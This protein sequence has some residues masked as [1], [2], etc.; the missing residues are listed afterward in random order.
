MLLLRAALQRRAF[1]TSRNAYQAVVVDGPV[2]APTTPV[3]VKKPMGAFRG[4]YGMDSF[5]FV[6]KTFYTLSS[7]PI[8]HDGGL[9]LYVITFMI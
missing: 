8:W 3:R 6:D 9:L 5:C 2:V 7:I 4:G 1:T